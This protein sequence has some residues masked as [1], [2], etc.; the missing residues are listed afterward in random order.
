MRIG[1]MLAA[2]LASIGSAAAA[3]NPRYLPAVGTT[4]T[5]R[6]LVTTNSGGNERTVGQVYRVAITANDGTTAEGTL[7]PLALVWHC[8]AADTSITCKQARYLPNVSREGDLL[9]AP[10]PADISGELGKV[11]KMTLRDLLHVTQVYPLPGLQDLGETEQ[12]RIGSVPL[13][14]QTTALDCDE[15]ALRPFFPFGS[16]ARIS[17]VCKMTVEVSRS[18][19]SAVKD[20]TNTHDVTYELSF[21]GHEHIA[22]PAGAYEVAVIKF[23]ST[24][25]SAD[26]AITEGD[27]EFAENLGLSAKY[28]SLTRF[29]KSTNTTRVVRELIKVEP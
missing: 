29:P 4:A 9:T 2:M 1:L 16:A 24:A 18:R 20:A 13:A 28:S 6:L 12:P 5:F 25:D 14:I 27:W 26:G 11:G 3:D 22:V 8:P 7:T 17:V 23:K 10:L 19:L 15:A 21:A